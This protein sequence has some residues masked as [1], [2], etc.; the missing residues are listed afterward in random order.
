MVLSTQL[1]SIYLLSTYL[2]FWPKV[3]S[4]YLNVKLSKFKAKL[5]GIIRITDE[6]LHLPRS[7]VVTAQSGLMT[8]EEIT[9]NDFPAA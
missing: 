3:L 5:G 4:S 8:D 7:Y 1:R 2:K 9:R 6:S